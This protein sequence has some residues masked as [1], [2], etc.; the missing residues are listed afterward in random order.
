MH[1]MRSIYIG[2]FAIW[3]LPVTE[4]GAAVQVVDSF[5][6]RSDICRGVVYQIIFIVL[7]ISVI[8]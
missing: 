5:M 7:M 6:I 2:M 4:F 1:I 3:R 8:K